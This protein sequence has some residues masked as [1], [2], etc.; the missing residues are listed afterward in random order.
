MK[1]ANRK[2]IHPRYLP[3]VEEALRGLDLPKKMP[4]IVRQ[5]SAQSHLI[6]GTPI[7]AARNHK[8]IAKQNKGRTKAVLGRAGGNFSQP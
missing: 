5:V 7:S 3:I 6:P 1:Y 8:D 4:V 2:S